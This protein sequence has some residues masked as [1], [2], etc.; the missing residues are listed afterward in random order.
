[1]ASDPGSNVSPIPGSPGLAK[2]FKFVRS[3][4]SSIQR[5]WWMNKGYRFVVRK[6]WGNV[7]I[8][9]R[10]V[11]EHSKFSVHLTI[12]TIFLPDVPLVSNLNKL[13]DG[14]FFQISE[15]ISCLLSENLPSARIS[16][17]LSTNQNVLGT[18]SVGW[19]N[20]G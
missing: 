12:I 9:L 2:L 11:L 17:Q 4:Y 6:K 20:D 1:M 5:G 14:F 10:A 15:R 3:V 18:I 19:V 7:H 8:M 13:F 16:A